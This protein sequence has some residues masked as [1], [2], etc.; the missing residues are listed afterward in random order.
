MT[1]S[2]ILKI[3]SFIDRF[4]ALQ[5]LQRVGE[6][7]FG[8]RR[9][10]NQ[11]LYKSGYWLDEVR[12][13][14]ILR[15]EAND[16]AMPGYKINRRIL[17]HHINPITLN[18]LVN[19]DPLIFDPENLICVSHATHQAIHYGDVNLLPSAYAERRPNDQIAWSRSW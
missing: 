8:D 12:P 10:L 7:T 6:E 15:D 11:Q 13:K 5:R 3:D 4:K 19:R 17:I 16:L 2:E 18:M 1:Y 14:I 9:F